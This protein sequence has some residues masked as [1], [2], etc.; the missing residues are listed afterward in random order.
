[1]DTPSSSYSKLTLTDA[2]VARLSS[3]EPSGANESDALVSGLETLV[4]DALTAAPTRPVGLLLSGGLDSSLLGALLAR[5][6]AGV[7]AFT[8]G[9]EG[10]AD[11]QAAQAVADALDLELVPCLYDERFVIR[12]LPALAQFLR[13]RGL[14]TLASGV[15][16]EACLREA[17]RHGI[18]DLWAGNGLDLIFGGGLKAELFAAQAG[19]NGKSF[20][21][22]FWE[23]TLPLIKR[24]YGTPDPINVYGRLGAKY[25]IRFHLPFESLRALELARSIDA[26]TLFADGTDKAPLRRLALDL[27]VPP[28]VAHRKKAMF[29]ESSGLFEMLSRLAIDRVTEL[30]PDQL[31][32]TCDPHADPHLALRYFVAVLAAD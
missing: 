28:V 1:V 11:L 20:H 21:D 23:Y 32:C 19:Q 14:H 9:R 6:G 29:Q 8:A 26:R 12:E 22:G 24:W 16:L 3:I 31:S 5:A 18:S 15:L 13:F 10:S 25:Q 2:D 27:G 7:V 30:A 17:H 4:A